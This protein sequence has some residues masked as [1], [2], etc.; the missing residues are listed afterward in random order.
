MESTTGGNRLTSANR[1]SVPWS[2]RDTLPQLEGEKDLMMTSADTPNTTRVR[3]FILTPADWTEIFYCLDN[4][5]DE[6]GV[7]IDE[8][9]ANDNAKFT[10]VDWIEIYISVKA[11]L[12]LMKSGLYG[13]DRLA[14]D[15]REH[16][17]DILGTLDPIRA[18]FIG[19]E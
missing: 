4:T 17:T 10:D 14:K 12:D 18:E 9:A 5:E 16:L 1:D 11:K 19:G 13:R 8:E 2:D 7:K 15:W 3:A 6:L